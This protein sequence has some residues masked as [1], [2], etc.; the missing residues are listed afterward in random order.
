MSLRLDIEEISRQIV[1]LRLR[2]EEID[3]QIAERGEL[4]ELEEE[5]AK[6]LEQ[7]RSLQMRLT[8]GT[9]TRGNGNETVNE[10]L[11]YIRPA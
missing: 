6:L 1:D 2:I 3:A 5:K 11:K 10:E 8:G 4:P 9:P 7:R